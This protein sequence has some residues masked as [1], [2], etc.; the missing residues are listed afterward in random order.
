MRVTVLAG[1]VGAAR[2]LAGLVQVVEPA[3]ITAIV[4][5]GDDDEF[6]GLHVSPDLDTVMYTL[7]GLVSPETGWGIEGDTSHCLEM[8]GCYGADTWFRLGDRDLATHLRRTALLRAGRTLAEATEELCRPLNV[9]V[10]VLPMTNDPV[11]TKVRT[12]ERTLA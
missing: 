12:P 5:V 8:L 9:E 7:A 11:R 4:N 10:R 6:Y 2:F 1:G 3:H